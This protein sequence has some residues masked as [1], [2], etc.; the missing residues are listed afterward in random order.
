LGNY[1]ASFVYLVAN[2]EYDMVAGEVIE[3]LA[4]INF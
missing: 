3:E 4:K 1:L 2:T